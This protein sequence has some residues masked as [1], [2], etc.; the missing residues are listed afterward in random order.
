MPP[1]AVTVGI[2]LSIKVFSSLNKNEM[3]SVVV[4]LN[5]STWR[6]EGEWF[7]DML[8]R[9]LSIFKCFCSTVDEW[10]SGSVE[11]V[12]GRLKHWTRDQGVFGSIHA[13]MVM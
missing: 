9:K 4:M 8:I 13:A 6:T 10:P 2:V 1:I 5:S 7:C 3:L 12:A 11:R